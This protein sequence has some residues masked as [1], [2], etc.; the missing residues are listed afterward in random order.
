MNDLFV[1]IEY[2]NREVD[3]IDEF[4]EQLD[5]VC[6]N[7]VRP[8]WIPSCS[9]GGELWMTI[10]INSEIVAFLAGAIASGLVW[11][12]IKVGSKKY[13]FKPIFEALENL[14]KSNV[15]KYKGI[16]FLT[17]D[18]QFDDCMIHIGGL[19][20]SFSSVI[21]LTF[22]EIAK[23]KPQFES[24][25]GQE[26]IKI[27]LPIDY[28]EHFDNYYE[29]FASYVIDYDKPSESIKSMWRITFSTDFPV[30]IYNFKL[31]KLLSPEDM[32][33]ELSE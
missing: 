14:R 33:K 18:L 2:N 4:K 24:K 11:D 8:K 30:L 32:A 1:S 16:E 20:N 26:I 28:V 6:L 23:L 13:V 5:N 15:E 7:Q 10:H 21:P 19:K 22:M 27:E 31:K 3:G 25:I 17:F 9:T 29:R 12:I